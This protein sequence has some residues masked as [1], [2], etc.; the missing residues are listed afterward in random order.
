MATAAALGT[1]MER[2][3]ATVIAGRY[4]LTVPPEVRRLYQLQE[5]DILEW[6]FDRDH[7]ML[8]IMP[9]R[10]QLITPQVEAEMREVRE[11]RALQKQQSRGAQLASTKLRENEATKKVG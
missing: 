2:L 7:G 8:T 9:K 5:G 11:Q 3:A 6:H 4:Q 10:A 1:A